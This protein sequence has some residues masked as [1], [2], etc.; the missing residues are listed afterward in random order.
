MPLTIMQEVKVFDYWG[1]DFVGPFPPS[2]TNEYILVGVDY[3]SK[4]VEAIPCAKADGKTVVTFLKKMNFQD[5]GPREY[6]SVMGVRIFA[7]LS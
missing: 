7:T 3:V 5:L 6:S 4:W 1:I 2:F